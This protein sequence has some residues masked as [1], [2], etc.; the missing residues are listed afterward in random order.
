MNSFK[1]F[2]SLSLIYIISI[3]S[4]IS[5]IESRYQDNFSSLNYSYILMVVLFYFVVIGLLVTASSIS[6]LFSSYADG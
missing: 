1:T 3:G 5:P 6:I 4:S 2:S